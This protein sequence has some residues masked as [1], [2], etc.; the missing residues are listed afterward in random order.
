MQV[1]RN[2][3]AIFFYRHYFCFL[4]IY[5][6]VTDKTAK[7]SPLNENHCSVIFLRGQQGN[8]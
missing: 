2:G 1:E 7:N 4:F 6:Q 8:F 3:M 5:L